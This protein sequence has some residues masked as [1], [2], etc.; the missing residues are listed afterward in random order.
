MKIHNRITKYIKP[1]PTEDSFFI[2]IIFIEGERMPKQYTEPNRRHE[3]GY[4]EDKGSVC[5]CT[6]C[7]LKIEDNKIS[8]DYQNQTYSFC[9]EECK[10]EFERTPMH[11]ISE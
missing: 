9:C 3:S 11:F 7:G 2:V 6:V 1:T 5:D 10:K 4:K 8:T